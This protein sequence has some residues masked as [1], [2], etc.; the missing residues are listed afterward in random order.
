MLGLD[1]LLQKEKHE[2]EA[3]IKEIE[4]EK[5]KN[6]MIQSC[7]INLKNTINDLSNEIKV[8][9]ELNRV[10]GLDLDN[11]KIKLI[12]VEKEN[13]ELTRQISS[14]STERNALIAMIDQQ[15]AAIKLQYNHFE[16]SLEMLHQRQA[17]LDKIEIDAG[18]NFDELLHLQ[19]NLES[20]LVN[21]SDTLQN[22]LIDAKRLT[23]M[24]ST[25]RE[26]MQATSI[27][28]DELDRELSSRLQLQTQHE[29]LKTEIALARRDLPKQTLKTT[30]LEQD[31]YAA[32]T[33]SKE[34][35]VLQ[36]KLEISEKNIQYWKNITKRVV[37][38]DDKF[39]DFVAKNNEM[40]TL[41]ASKSYSKNDGSIKQQSKEETMQIELS[42][43][44]VAVQE[45][46]KL[47]KNL[48]FI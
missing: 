47:G 23:G 21:E 32:A 11:N 19:K 24:I 31:N 27:L 4:V 7:E 33:K 18:K 30:L 6:I 41:D 10:N 14:I 9:T 46:N 22:E 39:H 37:N 12:S 38:N 25:A 1:I 42:S 8:I 48:I 15:D 16:L 36:Y 5:N 35:I 43:L 26:R 17:D 34:L 3:L 13:R 28:Q 45:L 20:L 2:K 29:I 44:W 40:N